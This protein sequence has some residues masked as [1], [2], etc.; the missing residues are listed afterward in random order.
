MAEDNNIL[1]PPQ[2]GRADFGSAAASEDLKPDAAMDIVV[3][4]GGDDDI[5]T[6]DGALP[7]A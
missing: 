2:F 4:A 6:V 7:T 5:H 1:R 3:Y